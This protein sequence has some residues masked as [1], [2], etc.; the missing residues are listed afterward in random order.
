VNFSISANAPAV[1]TTRNIS[2]AISG[3]PTFTWTSIAN[4]SYY[5]LYVDKAGGAKQLDS[6]YNVTQLNCR[7]TGSTCTVTPSLA[8]PNGS[9][10]WYLRTWG[11][12]G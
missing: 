6:W 3:Q 5:E 10:N 7:T 2:N 12:G 9:Y 4:A 1:V 11:P 8:L